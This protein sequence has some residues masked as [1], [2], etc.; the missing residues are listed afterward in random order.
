MKKSINRP[1]P[2]G[3][4]KKYKHCCL[5]YHKGKIP[6]TPLELMKSRYSAY[7]FGEVS[8]ILKTTHPDFRPQDLSNWKSEIGHFCKSDF[9]ALTILSSGWNENEGFVEF[10]AHIDN[11]VLKEKSRFVKVEGRWYYTQGDVDVHQ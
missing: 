11:Y 3:S 4:K 9:Q 2:C 7:A 1:C 10:E 8:Y 5:L 6:A